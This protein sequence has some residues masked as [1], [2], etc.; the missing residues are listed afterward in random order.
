MQEAKESAPSLGKVLSANSL[1]MFGPIAGLIALWSQFQGMLQ[2][3]YS[4][5]FVI[6]SVGGLAKDALFLFC[7]QKM[8]NVKLGK[9]QFNFDNHYIRPKQRQGLVLMEAPSSSM[10]FFYKKRPL[11]VSNSDK[12]LDVTFFRG[13]FKND[14]LL[15]EA[16]DYF[17]DCRQNQENKKSHSIRYRVVNY[18]GSDR[19][20]EETH[21]GLSTGRTDSFD[22]VPVFYKREDLGEPIPEDPFAAL[23]YVKDI[24]DFV[25]E[26]DFWVKS[27]KWYKDHLLSHSFGA[28]FIGG[29][30][31]GKTSLVKALAQKYDMPVFKFDL[32]S[33]DNR[34]FMHSWRRCLEN[35]PCITLFEDFDRLF[36]KEKQF[37]VG[38]QEKMRPPM[39]L[40][41]W[42]NA[43][44]GIED[45]DGIVTIVTVNDISN[46]D[47]AI[48]VPDAD[49]KSTRP[50][51][52]DRPV[53]FPNLDEK[54]KRII[55]KRILND[56]SMHIEE[57]VAAGAN[58][59]GAQF[60]SRCQT[61][62][63]KEYWKLFKSDLEQ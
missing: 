25:R 61:I 12:G 6:F 47:T 28:L 37:L 10:T 46:L 20:D 30:G 42:L 63:K 50:G 15:Q 62:A 54:A 60:T 34:E 8:T 3:F 38:K 27:K 51:R 59:S 45:S 49:G 29:P 48:G 9:R 32:T 58:E 55:A 53:F 31:T 24:E 13:T 2:R 5:F 52:L 56:C 7:M 26:F 33:M 41:C 44:N 57:A 17:E 14:R 16:L 36:N 40:D 19:K 4:V 22:N 39:T 11:F 23:S 43:V 1:L 35:T 18:Y 21:Q